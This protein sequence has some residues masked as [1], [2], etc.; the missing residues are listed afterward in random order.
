MPQF[1]L[2]ENR[3]SAARRQYPYLIDL[4]TDLLSDV[5][6]TRLV[7]PVARASAIKIPI[8]ELTPLVTFA[9]TEYIVDIPQMAAIRKKALGPAVGSLAR[10]RHGIIRA[11][12]RLITGS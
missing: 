8:A 12:D 4:Q 11:I 10:Q 3:D 2:H 9:S 7:A 1:S 5:P 6:G